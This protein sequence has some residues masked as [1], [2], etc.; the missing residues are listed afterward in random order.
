MGFTRAQAEEIEQIS[1]RTAKNYLSDK[2][3]ME[4]FANN[5]AELVMRKL[6]PEID[7]LTQKCNSLEGDIKHHRSE[8]AEIREK[9]DNME[10]Q[11]KRKCLRFY[12]VTEKVNE[13][14]TQLLCELVTSKMNVDI[15]TG[16]VA[17]CYRIGQQQENNKPRPIYVKFRSMEISARVY[18]NKKKMNATKI[19]IREEL[20]RRRH[21]LLIQV[22]EKVGRRNVWTRK[23][24]IFCIHDGRRLQID[25]PEDLCGRLA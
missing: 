5:L 12:G 3:F 9:L 25:K 21:E 10:Q 11:K 6:T 23:G 17:V 18:A 8:N 15:S 13:D 14:T 24:K 2:A 7:R 19:I 20:T 16:D 4:L 22:A 1:Q